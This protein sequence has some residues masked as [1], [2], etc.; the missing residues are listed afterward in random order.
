MVEDLYRDIFC[1]GN[2]Q[3]FFSS[4][5]SKHMF[6]STPILTL[7]CVLI[8]LG[9]YFVF[10]YASH[11]RETRHVIRKCKKGEIC[12][13]DNA[14]SANKYPSIPLVLYEYYHKKDLKPNVV[15]EMNALAERTGVDYKVVNRNRKLVF[16]ESPSPPYLLVGSR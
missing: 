4:L 5:H 13:L 11:D 9:I 6:V 1:L 10:P 3:L 16:L 7:G 15:K 12:Y 8:V 14:F 2:K